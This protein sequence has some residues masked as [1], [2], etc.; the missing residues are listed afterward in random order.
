MRDKRQSDLHGKLI[1]RFSRTLRNLSFSLSISF[2]IGNNTPAIYIRARGENFVCRKILF[3]P[4]RRDRDVNSPRR[5]WHRVGT[6]GSLRARRVMHV[7]SRFF[8]AI[9]IYGSIEEE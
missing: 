8:A 3:S 6:S 5:F 7:H 2:D 1:L 9:W 4:I